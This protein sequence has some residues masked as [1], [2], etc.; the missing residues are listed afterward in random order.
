MHLWRTCHI[1][2]CADLL[3][4][5]VD[6]TLPELFPIQCP[7]DERRTHAVR[8]ICLDIALSF[9][10]KLF[11][12]RYM[13]QGVPSEVPRPSVYTCVVADGKFQG[14]HPLAHGLVAACSELTLDI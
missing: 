10:E 3:S 8:E 4:V 1:R 6:S 9:D 2:G 12:C 5:P 14:N 11:T 7:L 13:S